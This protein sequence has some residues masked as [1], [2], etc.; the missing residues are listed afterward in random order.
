ML[1]KLPSITIFHSYVRKGRLLS[2][3]KSTNTYDVR[4]KLPKI[5]FYRDSMYLD[6]WFTVHNN[7]V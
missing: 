1:T 6:Y 7:V 5:V 4:L 2:K 3:V